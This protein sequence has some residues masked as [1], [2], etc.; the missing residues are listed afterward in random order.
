M[1]ILILP[2]L[3]CKGEASLS[4][5]REISPEFKHTVFM[6]VL[7]DHFSVAEVGLATVYLG[8]V[9]RAGLGAALPAWHG[10][11]DERGVRM[12]RKITSFKSL[13]SEA[14]RLKRQ[15]AW[16]CMYL[17]HHPPGSDETRYLE[18]VLPWLR[19]NDDIQCDAGIVPGQPRPQEPRV[20]FTL[21]NFN[22]FSGELF[23]LD[24]PD[25]DIPEGT[26]FSYQSGWH[27][28]GDS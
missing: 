13:H 28:C 8:C 16:A 1:S 23:Y 22:D 24:D 25:K 12:K 26:K 10:Q 19:P 5:F 7:P 17:E 14:H 11:S 6:Q 18:C 9:D 3:I 20:T 21:K 2:R 27:P 4:L 15:G